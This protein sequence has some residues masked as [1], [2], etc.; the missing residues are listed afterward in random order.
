MG[1]LLTGG[2]QG[3]DK[4]GDYFIRNIPSQLGLARACWTWVLCNAADLPEYSWK[5]SV[6]ALKPEAAEVEKMLVP[7][8]NEGTYAEKL[9]QI[10]ASL[11]RA[12]QLEVGLLDP[13]QP[14]LC[15]SS[16]PHSQA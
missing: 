14:E 2:L 9:S 3:L 15:E 4:L 1:S 7:D 11:C 16:Q 13:S 12:C 6:P 5:V 8:A 10:F